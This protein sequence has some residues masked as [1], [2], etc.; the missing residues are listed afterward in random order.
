MT[1]SPRTLSRLAGAL[2]LVTH[3]TSIGAVAAY[4]GAAFP[5]GVLL[6]FVLALGCLGTGVLVWALLRESVPVRASA[7][8]A[9]RALE[10]AVILAGT[11]PMLVQGWR[12]AAPGALTDALTELHTASFLVG[13]GLVISVNTLILGWALLDARAAPRTLAAL[14]IAGGALVLSSNLAQLFGLIPLNG[15][16][17]GLCALPVFAFELWFAGWLIVRGIDATARTIAR[18]GAPG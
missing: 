16:V 14:G 1:A 3:A 10:A 5:G 13:Q 2:Y 11:L 8:A 7:F 12:G 17:A 9:M 18:Q 4:A 15:A 6:E